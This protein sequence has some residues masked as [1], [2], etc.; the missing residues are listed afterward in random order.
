[1][2]FKL[3][4]FSRPPIT[5]ESD[6]LTQELEWK[7]ILI[8]LDDMISSHSCI[9]YKRNKVRCSFAGHPGSTSDVRSVALVMRS[10]F[11]YLA[12]GSIVSRHSYQRGGFRMILDAT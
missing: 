9:P 6:W 8:S 7:D 2:S 10:L 3:G 4:K 12:Q 1:M 5:G 11:K